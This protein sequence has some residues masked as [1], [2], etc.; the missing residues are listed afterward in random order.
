MKTYLNIAL[1][2]MLLAWTCMLGACDDEFE[3][4][5]LNEEFVLTDINITSK[6]NLILLPGTESQ[7]TYK[8]GP[9]KAT[10]RE[11]TWWVDDEKVATVD[12]NGL[13]HAIAPGKTYV[14][15][16]SLT[17]YVANA[18]ILLTV[19][20]HFIDMATLTISAENG[21][22]EIYVTEKLQLIAAYTPEDVTFPE[23]EWVSLNPD[24]LSV[25]SNGLVTALAPGEGTIQ[26][27]STD[28]TGLTAS[29]QIKAKRIIPVDDI[30][31]AP[32]DL[33]MAQGQMTKLPFSVVPADATATAVEWS[34]S[35]QSILEISSD[36]IVTV[37]ACG[38][39]KLTGKCGDIVKEFDVTV[40]EGYI[41][42]TFE[43]TMGRYKR[44]DKGEAPYLGNGFLRM[45]LNDQYSPKWR[46]ELNRRTTTFH[47]GKYPVLAFCMKFG[48]N[49][50]NL[51]NGSKHN[52]SLWGGNQ[53]GDYGGKDSSRLKIIKM[54]DGTRVYYADLS[55]NGAGF[56]KAE[57]GFLPDAPI[58]YDNV[59]LTFKD[60]LGYEA[61]GATYCDFFWVKT[62]TS[63][64]ELE[65]YIAN[66]N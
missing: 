35:D 51:D 39:A 34:S 36:A 29:Y 55:H 63:I 22:N 14:H 15:V 46:F 50:T 57:G 37:K 54:A 43:F 31:I 13:I 64:E 45:P 66:R 58:T 25:D 21:V 41:N 28:G 19:V 40:P 61:G 18:R 11:L 38:S 49:P 23:L 9:D 42:D 33:I 52:L 27:K 4:V 5:P 59:N 2:V 6:T 53:G 10:K 62:F 17:G 12:Q 56:S 44:D 8:T 60:I 30:V 48:G 20:D 47:A 3:N 26:A 65:N 7:V 16:R 32:E 1:K 24:I